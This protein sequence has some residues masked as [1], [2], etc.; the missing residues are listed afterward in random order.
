VHLLYIDNTEHAIDLEAMSP[1]RCARRWLAV[2]AA[3]SVSDGP[4]PEQSPQAQGVQ[5]GT[6]EVPGNAV[7][8]G[9]RSDQDSGVRSDR[10]QPELDASFHAMWGRAA[11]DRQSISIAAY[12]TWARGSHSRVTLLS[13]L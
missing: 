9:R 11:S 1:K 4:L 5:R 7:A 8:S 3:S 6:T 10:V 12:V 13:P 2:A